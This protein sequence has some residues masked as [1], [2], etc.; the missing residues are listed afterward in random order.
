MNLCDDK[1]FRRL[2]ATDTEYVKFLIERIL[3]TE[4]MNVDEVYILLSNLAKEDCITAVL[5]MKID[6]D[7]LKG[8]SKKVFKSSKAMDCPT[9]CFVKGF[10]RKLNKYANYDYLAYFFSDISRF[11]KGREYFIAKRQ[12]YD[13]VVPI[14]KLLCS[15]KSTTVRLE[16]KVLLRPLKTHS[17]IL[18]PM[19][20]CF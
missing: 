16:E 12:E 1:Q 17:L 13:G 3:D 11:K 10:D 15:Q 14:T 20:G 7:K 8:E 5:D 19:K 18:R 2:V 6:L 4:N 9:D